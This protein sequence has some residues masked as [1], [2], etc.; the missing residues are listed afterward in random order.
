MAT[1]DSS[2]AMAAEQ[3]LAGE[4]REQCEQCEAGWNQSFDK[5]AGSLAKEG[6]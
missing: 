5:L 4:M 2:A 1:N 3:E 6:V